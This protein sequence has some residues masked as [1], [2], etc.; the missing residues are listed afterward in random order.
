M[1]HCEFKVDELRQE[2]VARNLDS[3]GLK[4]QLAVRLKDALDEERMK[5]EG[6]VEANDE[7]TTSRDETDALSSKTKESH[8]EPNENETKPLAENESQMDDSAT[9]VNVISNQQAPSLNSKLTKQE[10][11]KYY[12]LPST[13]HLIVHPSSTA[14]EGKLELELVTLSTLLDYRKDDTKE[15]IFEVS[16][17]AESFNEMIMRDF[18][19]NIYKTLLSVY[20]EKTALDK[21]AADANTTSAPIGSETSGQTLSLKRKASHDGN[22]DSQEYKDKLLEK[23]E[24]RVKHEQDEDNDDEDKLVINDG[25]TSSLSFR[26]KSQYNMDFLLSFAY[27]D[28]YRHG[29]AYEKDLEDLLC[30]IGLSLSKSKIRTIVDK[31]HTNKDGRF[32]YRLLLSEKNNKDSASGF[33]FEYPNEADIVAH[34]L[35]FDTYSFENEP[36]SLL[37]DNKDVVLTDKLLKHV[38]FVEVNGTVVDVRN[39]MKR[40]EKSEQL[41]KNLEFKLKDSNEQLSM[42]CMMRLRATWSG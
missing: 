11:E 12:K 18:A 22:N 30:C 7:L 29:Y 28:T 1:C 39:T 16:L 15:S 10:R 35:N 26:A 24:K 21:S 25:S 4:A 42:F 31:I 5:V 33:K 3:K 40:L 38:N 17:F 14:R 8:P 2:L 20:C 27:F 37:S 34:N 23:S 13:P 19:F 41:A 9:P 6:H 32:N 36:S